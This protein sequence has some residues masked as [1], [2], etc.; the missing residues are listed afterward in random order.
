MEN[1]IVEDNKN[2]TD[3]TKIND[4]L[5]KNGKL[6]LQVDDC[7]TENLRYT[8]NENKGLETMHKSREVP[9]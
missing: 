8:I 7:V 5:P 2:K 6:K 9:L 4:P 1:E 3:N